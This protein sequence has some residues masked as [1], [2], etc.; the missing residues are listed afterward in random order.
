MGVED[1]LGGLGGMAPAAGGIIGGMMGGPA[2]AMLGSGIGGLA[3]GALGGAALAGRQVQNPM[4]EEQ[5]RRINGAI[6]QS[7]QQ[8]N[9]AYGL[10]NKYAGQPMD[11]MAGVAS[12][13]TRGVTQELLDYQRN[14]NIAQANALANSAAG[15]VNPAMLQ[16]QAQNQIA[17]SNNQANAQLAPLITQERQQANQNLFN[18]VQGTRDYQTK[19]ME[20]ARTYEMMGLSSNQA[21]MQAQNQ[22]SAIQVQN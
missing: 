18:M 20:L 8:A 14:Q 13:Q 16:R 12:G 11:Y 4:S 3:A 15:G 5:R 17:L 7:T 1:I 10:A 22:L 9:Q 21:S 6:D 2:G 19:L